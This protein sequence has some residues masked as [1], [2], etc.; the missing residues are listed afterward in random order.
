MAVHVFIR[1]MDEPPIVVAPP[2]ATERA[3]DFSLRPELVTY[4]FSERGLECSIDLGEVR[5][6]IA[7]VLKY[8]DQKISERS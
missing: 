6:R 7:G 4:E 5:P 2:A 1:L 3:I 8:L